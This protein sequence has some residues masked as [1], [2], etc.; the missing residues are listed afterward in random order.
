M[1]FLF[2]GKLTHDLNP[3]NYVTPAHPPP[4][5]KSNYSQVF[6]DSKLPFLFEHVHLS[7]FSVQPQEELVR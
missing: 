6:D 2:P 7:P 5:G 3:A 4:N 1:I